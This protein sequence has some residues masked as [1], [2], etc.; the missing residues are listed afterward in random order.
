MAEVELIIRRNGSTKVI[1]DVVLKDQEGNVI[2]P[3]ETP[4][5][6]CRCGASKIKPFCDGTHRTIG[7]VDGTDRMPG[8]TA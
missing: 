6:L 7:W 4:F 8:H 2:E 3:P 5:K 1:G